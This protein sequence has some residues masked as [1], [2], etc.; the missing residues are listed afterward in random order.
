MIQNKSFKVLGKYKIKSIYLQVAL[1]LRQNETTKDIQ[2]DYKSR[3][4]Y[5]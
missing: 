5:S 2:I 3:R 1:N 4:F